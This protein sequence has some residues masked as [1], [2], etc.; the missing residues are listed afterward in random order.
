MLQ[1]RPFFLWRF[2]GFSFLV[3]FSYKL[4]LLFIFLKLKNKLKIIYIKIKHLN[5]IPIN[6]G[7][8]LS[9]PRKSVPLWQ[10]P[11]A[12]GGHSLA[13]SLSKCT[14]V[15]M[16]S[17]GPN[18]VLQWYG[19]LRQRPHLDRMKS[20]S[21]NDVFRRGYSLDWDG[22]VFLGPVNS[23]PVPTGRALAYEPSII[24]L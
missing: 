10:C 2:S 3:I 17:C 12:V 5:T 11:A 19:Q 18:D 15:K 4:L 22:P 21:P 9:L 23:G 1:K 8:L 14:P 16:N 20:C 7:K 13:N 6:S 24:E